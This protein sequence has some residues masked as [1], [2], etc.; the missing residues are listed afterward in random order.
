MWAKIGPLSERA[1]PVKW[2]WWIKKYAVRH[3][4]LLSLIKLRS[5]PARL[6]W[7]FFQKGRLG[8]NRA[9]GLESCPLQNMRLNS[10]AT[11]FLLS[12]LCLTS[13]LERLRGYS[14]NPEGL[15]FLAF[16]IP[17]G[18]IQIAVFPGFI[19]RKKS[20]SSYTTWIQIRDDICMKEKYSLDFSWSHTW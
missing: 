1:C 19:I 17:L 14:G 11:L 16:Q 7:S 20:K 9:P 18:M 4:T 13:G 2:Q 3:V 10:E 5:P 6:N 12:T 8:R 15:G